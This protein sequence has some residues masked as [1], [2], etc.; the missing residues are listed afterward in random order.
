MNIYPDNSEISWYIFINLQVRITMHS[1]SLLFILLIIAALIFIIYLIIKY[2]QFIINATNLYEKM[3]NHQDKMV[4]LLQDIR[5]N[6]K[7]F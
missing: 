3:V 1:S 6:T 7:K 5:D 2:L 4:K